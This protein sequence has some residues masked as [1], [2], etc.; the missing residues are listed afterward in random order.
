MG[1]IQNLYAGLGFEVRLQIHAWQHPNGSMVIT[2][3]PPGN[4]KQTIIGLI[5][6]LRKKEPYKFIIIQS[7]ML[8]LPLKSLPERF[9]VLCCLSLK[10]AV[11]TKFLSFAPELRS[12]V[13]PSLDPR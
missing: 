9:P 12:Q 11:R 8:T 10:A 3:D 4:L 2:Q 5:I 1:P 13:R 6:L 7:L